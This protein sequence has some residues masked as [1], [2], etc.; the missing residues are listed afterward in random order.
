MTF[1]ASQ[2]LH[3]YIHKTYLRYPSRV[4]ASDGYVPHSDATVRSFRCNVC[5]MCSM[6]FVAC[7]N[8]YWNAYGQQELIYATVITPCWSLMLSYDMTLPNAN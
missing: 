1:D 8:M 2:D 6:W 5:Y 3:H 4:V 7:F